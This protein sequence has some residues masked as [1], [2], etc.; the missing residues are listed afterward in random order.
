MESVP[1]LVSEPIQ[2][3]TQIPA[4]E[5]AF[6]IYQT[7]QDDQDTLRDKGRNSR[8]VTEV[9][10]L[11]TEPGDPAKA[12][13]PHVTRQASLRL[14]KVVHTILKKGWETGER[15]L[16]QSLYDGMAAV[17]REDVKRVVHNILAAPSMAR[18]RA[19]KKRFAEVPFSLHYIKPV[20]GADCLLDGTIDFA[21]L[22]DNAWV[23][24][25]FKTDAIPDEEIQLRAERDRLQLGL[26]ALAL[27]EL[28]A[29]RVKDLISVF[30][31]SSQ[32]VCFPWNEATRVAV[33]ASL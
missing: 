26:Y 27:E 4:G 20:N 6:Q 16:S 5:V 32:D 24:L 29:Y 30:A 8:V 18:A 19:A 31:C 9:T 25:D 28:T 14:G 15:L 11:F 22:E 13:N 7:W 23:I 2:L 1:E 21:F 17:E 3:F 12:R 10:D 33:Q